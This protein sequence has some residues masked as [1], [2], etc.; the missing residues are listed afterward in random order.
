MNLPTTATDELIQIEL[1]KQINEDSSA[2]IDCLQLR[3]SLLEYSSKTYKMLFDNHPDP[4]AVIRL[5]DGRL[6]EA[7]IGFE[8]LLGYTKDEFREFGIEHFLMHD[9]KR[10]KKMARDAL[11]DGGWF[12]TECSL[13]SRD[14]G[15]VSVA[16]TASLVKHDEETLIQTSMRKL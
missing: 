1:Q 11:R 9:I 16:L 7:N 13:Q 8:K 2:D 5:S 6:L 4:I 12:Q 14:N 10:L 15:L 3:E